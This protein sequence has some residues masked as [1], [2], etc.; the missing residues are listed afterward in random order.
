M[1][2]LDFIENSSILIVNNIEETLNLM[3]PKYPLHS[4]RVIKNEEKEE[5]LIAQANETIKEAFIATSEKKYLFLCGS[6]FRKEAQNALL[7]ILEE[8]P[9]N[10]VFILITN[11]KTSLLPT[12]Y[13]RLPYK[14]LKK[15]EQKIES[16]LDLNRLDLKDIYTFLQE[17]QKISKQEAKDI[18]ESLLLKANN[19]KIKLSQKKLDFFSKAIKLLELNSKPINV[20]TTLLLYLSNQKNQN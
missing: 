20:L 8:P 15:S 6:T 11:S 7:K 5:F 4:V 9:R 18:V 16:S 14:Y 17:N 1:I 3:L 13:S 10:I 2:L 12:I 19:Q